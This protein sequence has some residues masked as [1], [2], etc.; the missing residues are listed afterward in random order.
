MPTTAFALFKLVSGRSQ[1]FSYLNTMRIE[2]ADCR[3]CLDVGCGNESPLRHFGFEYSVGVEG[4]APA[5]EEAKRRKTH[6]D[7]RLADVTALEEQ[8]STKQFDCC[9]ALD[10]IEHLT[11]EDGMKLLRGMERVAAKKILIFTPNGFLP[12]QSYN[13]NDLQEHL[14][15]WTA[16]EMQSLGFRVYGMY[17]PKCLRGEYHRH[18]LRPAALWGV[19]AA[20]MHFLYTKWKPKHA[21]AIL[22]VK[23][24]SS[25]R[26]LPSI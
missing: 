13:D 16:E 15:G 12:Q 25:N 10:L 1:R 24:I 6:D 21:A 26:N 11:K 2:L 14:S 5:L 23:E 8:F 20:L 18:R 22:C 7:F 3:T 19:I 4:H 17:G 9:V